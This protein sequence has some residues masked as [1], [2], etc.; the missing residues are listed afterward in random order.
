MAAGVACAVEVTA[1]VSRPGSPG[2]TGTVPGFA[3]RGASRTASVAPVRSVA[4][5]CTTVSGPPLAAGEAEGRTLC[6]TAGAGGTGGVARGTG[7]AA[8]AASVPVTASAPVPP[9]VG[10]GAGL[11]AVR[12]LS[13]GDAVCRAAGWSV[14]VRRCTEGVTG[15]PGGC[16]GAAA[17]LPGAVAEA[18]T[19]PP[20]TAR[21][22]TGGTGGT[23]VRAPAPGTPEGPPSRGGAE[24]AEGGVVVGDMEAVRAVAA[25][26]PAAEAV[27]PPPPPPPEDALT[28]AGAAAG[29]VVL[30]PAV[31]GPA[32][33]D[34]DRCTAAGAGVL[35]EAPPREARGVSPEEV[36]P[37]P[38][39]RGRDQPPLT[40]TG[41]APP[42]STARCT[43]ASAA[44]SPP[45]ARSPSGGAGT[46]PWAAVTLGADGSVRRCTAVTEVLAGARVSALRRGG[47]GGAGAT[48]GPVAGA[49]TTGVGCGAH[50]NG[51]AVEAA[52]V[53]V[54][55][56]WTAGIADWPVPC[57]EG[58]GPPAGAV[59]GADGSAGLGALFPFRAA[60]AVPPGVRAAGP[61]P[62]RPAEGT[63][64]TAGAAD[65][66][67]PAGPP[68]PTDPA[69]L[70][71]PAADPTDPTGPTDPADPT[72]PA[73]AAATDPAA[74]ADPADPAGPPPTARNGTTGT[75]ALRPAVGPGCVAGPV[76]PANGSDCTGR[77]RPDLAPAP[78]PGVPVRPPPARRALDSPS[79]T[80]CERVAVNEGFCQVGSRPPNPASATGPPVPS[81]RWIGGS[82]DQ[83]A[84]T[85]GRGACAGTSGAFPD[86]SASVSRP[87]PRIRSHSP[88]RQPSA[89]A[90]AV[91]L[92][93]RDA[94]SA[95]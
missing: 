48:R 14:P 43:T 33:D 44:V 12:P 13:G 17:G 76:G 37:S 2:A 61:S 68:G 81:A 77:S 19:P 84:A 95:V 47:T 63:R 91:A 60:P 20:L 69:D 34:A 1:T 87:R 28:G 52:A 78:A 86:S 42:F 31:D 24:G 66:A 72:Y 25:G 73:A 50:A 71:V 90:E 59:D 27:P 11:A 30:G 57:A 83:A 82:P 26:R 74:P 41:S 23:E 21:R 10:A 22:C 79:R 58:A 39:P 7:E 15:V 36:R 38:S 75:D 80:A 49:G 35:P 3:G 8:V 53:R 62:R 45:S 6:G 46:A 5:R 93:T 89:P 18:G 85:T 70:T 88:T 4:L 65:R 32:P 51:T 9:V 55:A 56:R 92:V 29:T 64:C 67:V 16:S 54:T 40:G 94:I